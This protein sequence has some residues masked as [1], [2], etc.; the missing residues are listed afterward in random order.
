MVC[1][2]EV[3]NI[4][5]VKEHE[6][7]H[8][9]HC[10]RCAR[11]VSKDDFTNWICLGEKHLYK[12]LFLFKV[13][14]SFYSFPEEYEMDHL[15][16]IFDNFVLGGGIAKTQDNPLQL[17]LVNNNNSEKQETVTVKREPVL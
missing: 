10:L 16:S 13:L 12:W 17:A 4:F 7:K 11:Q 2:E 3:F 1:E 15:T 5:F 9:V 6:K 8:V 14:F